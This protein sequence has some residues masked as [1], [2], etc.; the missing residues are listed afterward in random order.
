[1]YFFFRSRRRVPSGLLKSSRGVLAVKP[2]AALLADFFKSRMQ[3]VKGTSKQEASELAAKAFVPVSPRTLKIQRDCLGSTEFATLGS[4]PQDFVAP[5]A[6][7]APAASA[8]GYDP[9][10]RKM[11]LLAS[12]IDLSLHPGEAP[13]RVKPIGGGAVPAP[14]ELK[15]P[16]I[17][18]RE[19]AATHFVIGGPHDASAVTAEMYRPRPAVEK[20]GVHNP[21]FTTFGVAGPVASFSA[22]KTEFLKSDWALGDMGAERPAVTETLARPRTYATATPQDAAA[23][24]HEAATARARRDQLLTSQFHL[25]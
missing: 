12:H 23:R 11:E 15:D 16:A 24:A 1:M 25:G 5:P 10:S 17:L 13:K 9:H 14:P 2:N 20:V 22:R 4:L 21:G 8:G 19:M 3:R 6:Y 18:K 7:T